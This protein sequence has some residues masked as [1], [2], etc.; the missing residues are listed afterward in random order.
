MKLTHTRLADVEAAFRALPKTGLVDYVRGYVRADG[1]F[2]HVQ[3]LAVGG[4]HYFFTHSDE[5]RESGRLL[6]ADRKR[7]EV[8][9]WYAI[10]PFTVP[11]ATP[12]FHHAGGCQLLGDVLVVA[13]ETGQRD[14]A[15]SVVAFFDVSEPTFPR[16]LPSLRI[17][18][19][20]SRAMAA[21]I[22]TIESAGKETLLVA[23]F[24]HGRVDFYEFEALDHPPKKPTFQI[25]IDEDEHG[26]FCSSLINRTECSR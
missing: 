6:V 4:G 8:S 24:E 21:D 3:G 7:K 9:A 10:P 1:S 16:E 13:C 20:A 26:H 22:T 17:E 25:P 2:S 19:G 11:P 5:N 14:Q 12:F 15:R 18:N 23:T